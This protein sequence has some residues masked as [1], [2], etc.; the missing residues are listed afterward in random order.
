[1]NLLLDTHSFIWWDSSPHL[2]SM[3]ARAALEDPTNEVRVSTISLWEIA[4]KAQLGKLTLHRPLDE[5]VS[6]QISQGL[7]TLVF[8]TSHALRILQLPH[9]HK[10]PFD[11]A[12]IAQAMVENATLVTRDSAIA[13]YQ[14][15]LL[16]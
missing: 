14:V 4:I 8:D 7:R 2:L 5:I 9:H 11:R 13:A 12:L 6:D 16:W 3:T 15:P 10:D 1:M